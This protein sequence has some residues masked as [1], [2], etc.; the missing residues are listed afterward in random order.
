M[1]ILTNIATQKNNLGKTQAIR[2]AE[3]QSE[4]WV[5]WIRLTIASVFALIALYSYA[6]GTI[7]LVSFVMLAG[8]S[9]VICLYSLG[10]IS[11]V[12]KTMVGRHAV[13]L[14]AFLDVT[15]VT[16]IVWAYSLLPNAKAIEVHSAVFAAYFI[17][18]A[19][20][21]LHHMISLSIFA[22][23]LSAVQYTLICAFVF[24]A[25]ADSPAS[26]SYI[27]ITSVLMLFVVAVL[28]GLISRNN[29]LSIQKVTVSEVRYHN[30]VHR[31]PQM[32][33]TLNRNGEILWSNMAAFAILGIPSKAVIGSKLR[34]HMVDPDAFKLEGQGMRGTFQMRDFNG[35]IKFV[36]CIIQPVKEQDEGGVAWEGSIADVTERELAI[37]QREEM[38]NRLFQYQK[39]ESLSTLASG[40]AHDFN[41]ILQ[42]AYDI[43]DR[44]GKN[45]REEETRH[46]MMLISEVLTDA[47]F[48]VS[49]LLA[50]GRKQP[51]DYSVM[52]IAAFLKDIIPRYKEQMGGAY[53]VELVVPEHPLWIQGDANYL[54]RIFQNLFGNA[55]DA[56]PG[57]GT[58]TVE[59]FSE[60]RAGETGNVVIRFCDTGTGI[61]PQYIDKIF[62][63]FFTTKKA[64]KGTGLGLALVRRIVQLHNGQVRVDKTGPD[65]TTFRIDIPE[66]EAGGE[67]RDTKSIML[68]RISSRLL[69]LDDDPKIRD[70][71]KFF[72]TE[73]DYKVCEAT[74]MEEGVRALKRYRQDCDVAIL[75]WKLGGENPRTVIESLRGVKRDIVI[76]IV[77]GY[78]PSE[79]DIKELGIFRW[80]TKP[81]DKNRLDFEIQKAL[82]LKEKQTPA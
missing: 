22:G 69:V 38:A 21:A 57:G 36:D 58:M 81:Y 17:P 42:T 68:S 5:S 56:M 53:G 2:L 41:N 12:Q 71:L 70:I 75:D 11:R 37:T 14:L 47:K 4:R 31:L 24:P 6:L 77:S 55:R 19:F 54:K 28:S 78:P 65:G 61:P 34:D 30:L 76:I 10:F 39:M 40:M 9:V 43:I 35:N 74:T 33:F 50:V 8:A 3:A 48:L 73:L 59:A 79:N 23:L 18:V 44:V 51:L 7:P 63:P 29:F 16:V 26:A 20:T 64:G 27:Y 1:E 67:G 49:E 60:R 32:L 72:L 25:G 45:T 80:F 52:D 13:F 66:C 82:H 15:M 46:N 62:D